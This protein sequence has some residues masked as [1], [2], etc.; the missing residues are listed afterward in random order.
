L[1]ENLLA[2]CRYQPWLNLERADLISFPFSALYSWTWPLGTSFAEL[3]TSVC[4]LI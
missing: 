2:Y 1:N 4:G 3:S